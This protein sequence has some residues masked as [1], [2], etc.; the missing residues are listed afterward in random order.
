MTAPLVTF[1]DRCECGY[2][3][4]LPPVV[5]DLFVLEPASGR[6]TAYYRC[7]VCGREWKTGWLPGSEEAITLLSGIKTLALAGGTEGK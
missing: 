6:V 7:P 2:E 5:P 4:D 3:A 1:T